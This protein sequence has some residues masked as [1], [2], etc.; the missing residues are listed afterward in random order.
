MGKR[1]FAA[2]TQRVGPQTASRTE[3]VES[4]SQVVA[5]STRQTLVY[6]AIKARGRVIIHAR[7]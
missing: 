2:G 7:A 5:C 4:R 3:F 6:V 1:Q